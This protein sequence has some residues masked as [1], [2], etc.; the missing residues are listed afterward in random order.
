M[1][2]TSEEMVAQTEAAYGSTGFH[3]KALVTRVEQHVDIPAHEK[4]A[5]RYMGSHDSGTWEATVPGH[6]KPVRRS[7]GVGHPRGPYREVSHDSIE[8]SHATYP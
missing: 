6:V 8:A 2:M 1:A 7:I 3:E 5:F 4:P